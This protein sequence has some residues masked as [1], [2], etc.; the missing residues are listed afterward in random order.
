MAITALAV[1]QHHWLWKG[2]ICQ[3]MTKTTETVLLLEKIGVGAMVAQVSRVLI[4][5]PVIAYIKILDLW[6]GMDR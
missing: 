1:K 4:D 3:P 2:S 6:I 5:G